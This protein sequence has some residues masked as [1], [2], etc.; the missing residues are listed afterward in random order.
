MSRLLPMLEICSEILCLA[1]VPIASIVITAPTPMIIPS[2]VR[3]DLI[4]LTIR[5]LRDIFIVEG[6]W[7]MISSSAHH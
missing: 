2:I 5:D 1:P 7:I 3:D 6:R 4:L